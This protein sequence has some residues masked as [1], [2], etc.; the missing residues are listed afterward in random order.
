MKSVHRQR[1]VIFDFDGTIADSWPAIIQVAEGVMKRKRPYNEE[2]ITA[3]R[4]MPL[5]ELMKVLGVPKWKLPI[6]LYRGR[7]MLRARMHGIPLH[8]GMATTLEQ[9][10]AKGVPLYVLS[11]NSTENVQ[12]YLQWHKLTHCFSGVYGGASLFGKASRLLKLIDETGTSVTDSWYVGDEMRDVTAARAV[13]LRVASVT[14]GYNTRAALLSKEPDV[15]VDDAA[16]LFKELGVVW[17]K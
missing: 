11:S 9:L 6:L 17:K 8:E 4:D 3:L 1:A 16:A 15:V 7:R 5:P 14:W 10:H 12:K 2:E 13:G